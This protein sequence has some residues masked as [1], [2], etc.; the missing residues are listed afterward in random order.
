ML[1]IEPC[2]HTCENL[3]QRNENLFSHRNPFTDVCNS[4]IFNSQILETTQ[5]FFNMCMDKQILVC[6]CNGLLLNNKKEWTIDI[7]PDNNL[8]GSQGQYAEW[9]NAK[10]QRLYII[11]L[12]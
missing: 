5:I 1:T 7:Y 6:P 8:D 12:H 4:F 10:L 3:C 9:K 2:N 11:W